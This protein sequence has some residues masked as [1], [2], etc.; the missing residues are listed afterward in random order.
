MHKGQRE[1]NHYILVKNLKYKFLCLKICTKL[2]SQL[3][4]EQKL[5]RERMN[6]FQANLCPAC[7][8]F[9][10][11]AINITSRS[12]GR[13]TSASNGDAGD[14]LVSD[15]PLEDIIKPLE[16][17]LKKTKLR[18]AESELDNDDV[19]HKLQNAL[20]ELES[21]RNSSS[22]SSAWLWKNLSFG[23]EHK[24]ASSTNSNSLPQ[25]EH[26]MSHSHSM[27]PIIPSYPKK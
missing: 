1:E 16:E 15:R 19:K 4:V 2:S 12:S 11:T 13:T 20:A 27:P 24:K 23:K 26:A 3:E 17:E 7:F 14:S 22:S 8:Q 18:L 10:T 21:Y 9:V 6:F 5:S 25:E